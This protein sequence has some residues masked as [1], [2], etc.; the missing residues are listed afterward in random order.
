LPDSIPPDHALLP[1]QFY[2]DESELPGK[3]WV[4]VPTWVDPSGKKMIWDT[5]TD[6]FLDA[7]INDAS[8]G[9]K[10]GTWSPVLPITGGT[11][12]GPLTLEGP[13]DLTLARDPTL[14]MHAVTLQYLDIQIANNPGP[15]GP[16]GPAGADGADGADS[17]V[18][19][20]AGPQGI[21]GVPGVAGADGATGPAGADGAVGPQGP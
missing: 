16:M 3:I 21:Q 4:G 1:Q 12:S 2:W 7:P 5:A 14:P 11:L 8:Y 20:P 17:T 9:R 13:Y 10:N 19:G 18:P 15:A 6:T